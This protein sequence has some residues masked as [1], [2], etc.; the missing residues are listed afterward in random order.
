MNTTII[1]A[2]I[3]AYEGVEDF[4]IISYSDIVRMNPRYLCTGREYGCEDDPNE[5]EYNF[6]AV[7]ARDPGDIN[8]FYAVEFE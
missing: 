5:P 6:Y 7:Y 8:R 3:P 1:P 4:T 2:Y